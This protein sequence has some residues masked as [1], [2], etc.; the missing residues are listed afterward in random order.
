MWGNWN[1]HTQL[2]QNGVVAV[3]NSLAIPQMVKQ[4]VTI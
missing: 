3:E 4:R 1:L 2:M